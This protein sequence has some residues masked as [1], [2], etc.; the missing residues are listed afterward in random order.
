MARRG[1]FERG[2]KGRIH[3]NGIQLDGVM[4]RASN[5]LGFPSREWDKASFIS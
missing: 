2:F 4:S 3:V 1:G 5:V